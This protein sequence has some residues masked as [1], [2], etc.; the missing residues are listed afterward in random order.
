MRSIMHPLLAIALVCPFLWKNAMATTY[1]VATFSELQTAIESTAVDGDVVELTA[2]ISVTSPISI[3]NRINVTSSGSQMYYLDGGGN[4]GIFSIYWSADVG[5]SKLNFQNGYSDTGGAIN[6][7]YSTSSFES[8]TFKSNI[9]DDGGAIYNRYGTMNFKSCIFESNSASYGGAICI[10]NEAV[11]FESCKFES[12]SAK[13]GDAIYNNM[14][15]DNVIYEDG[16]VNFLTSCSENDFALGTGDVSEGFNLYDKYFK[17]F[18]KENEN[19]NSPFSANLINGDN[20]RPCPSGLLN[21]GAGCEYPKPIYG[22]NFLPCTRFWYYDPWK[23][24]CGSFRFMAILFLCGFGVLSA[25]I[26]KKLL[27]ILKKHQGVPAENSGS[28]IDSNHVSKW[29]K[30]GLNLLVLFAQLDLVGDTV[31]L[32]FEVFATPLLELIG[33]LVYLLPTTVF[34][35]SQGGIVRRHLRIFLR[36]VL[37][38]YPEKRFF[39]Y[40]SWDEFYKFSLGIIGVFIE[41]MKSLIWFMIFSWY[42]IPV[43]LVYYLVMFVFVSSKL[44][45]VITAAEFFVNYGL[46]EN[47]KKKLSPETANRIFNGSILTELLIDTI[48]QLVISLLNAIFLSRTNG[49]F[50]FQVAT[51]SF[52]ILNEVYPFIHGTIKHRSLIKALENR[53]HKLLDL[54]VGNEQNENEEDLERTSTSVVELGKVYPEQSDDVQIHGENI[55][56]QLDTSDKKPLLDGNQVLEGMAE[57]KLHINDM[58]KKI[59]EICGEQAAFKQEIK[60]LR[61]EIEPLL[62]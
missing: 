58:D 60:N 9:A 36:P 56:L 54:Q 46:D 16:A 53:E 29:G 44:M 37:N 13:Y 10:Y 39:Q 11:S 43:T 17:D 8:C 51:S 27:D 20:C 6:N 2:D 22:I 59:S 15:Y 12:N 55:S 4:N 25:Y 24:T 32:A 33:I 5:F 28:D 19:E 14:V 18:D 62:K 1:Q 34:M 26:H 45:C 23:S 31:Y 47:D 21:I 3:R 41:C 50:F 61:S 42:V 57:M 52:V 49:L 30:Y 7:H 35:I 40:D 38:F 48:P